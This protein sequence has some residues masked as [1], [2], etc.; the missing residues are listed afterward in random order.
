MTAGGCAD[1]TDFI[2]YYWKAPQRS[3]RRVYIIIIMY[4][5]MMLRRDKKW[6]IEVGGKNSNNNGQELCCVCGEKEVLINVSDFVPKINNKPTWEMMW[7]F[8]K[9][10]SFVT[11]ISLKLQ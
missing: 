6:N 2:I 8:K 10:I 3:Q 9:H 11:D 7:R 4:T 1:M 5:Y